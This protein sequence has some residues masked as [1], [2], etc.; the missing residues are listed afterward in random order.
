MAA[1]LL[2]VLLA[3]GIA[4][5]LRPIR[6]DLV[7]HAGARVVG[8]AHVVLGR[9][10]LRIHE[11]SWNDGVLWLPL[12]GSITYDIQDPSHGFHGI[13]TRVALR[14]DGIITWPWHE[15][16]EVYG[17]SYQRVNRENGDWRFSIGDDRP[18][19]YRLSVDSDPGSAR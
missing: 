15:D 8:K 14:G 17:P 1:G 5:A 13:S 18:L 6:A 3:I 19:V 2:T 12:E 4:W 11:T 7:V 16:V 10:L 9:P